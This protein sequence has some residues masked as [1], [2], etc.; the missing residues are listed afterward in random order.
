VAVVGAAY[1]GTKEIVK[2]VVQL[3][4]YLI[5]KESSNNSGNS[6]NNSTSKTTSGSGTGNS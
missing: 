5:N 3:A 1:I 6:G 4:D 2:E